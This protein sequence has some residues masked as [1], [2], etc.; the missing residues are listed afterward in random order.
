MTVGLKVECL[1]A[2]Q[3]V[4]WVASRAAQKAETLVVWLVEPMGALKVA[5][6]GVH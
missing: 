3:A 4:R 5:L 1:A 6:T 2:L